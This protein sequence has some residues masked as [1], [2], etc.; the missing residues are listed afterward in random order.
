MKWQITQTVILGL[1]L[2]IATPVDGFQDWPNWRGPNHDDKSTE[3][4]LLKSWPEDGPAQVWVNRDVGIGYGGISVADGKLFTVGTDEKGEFT[5]CLDSNSGNVLWTKH[6]AD[7][8]MDRGRATKGWGD[9]SRSTPSVDGDKVYSMGASGVLAC[10]EVAN[11]NLVWSKKM[12]DL[13]GKVPTWGYS[14]S[15]LVDGNQVIC[16]PG[17][18]NGAVAAFDKNTGAKL[19]QSQQATSPAHYSSV[20]PVVVNGTKQYVQLLLKEAIGLNPENGAVIWSVPWEGRTAVIPSPVSTSEN[21]VYFTSGYGTGSMLVSLLNG[22][23]VWFDPG[24]VNHHGGVIHHEGFLYGFTDRQRGAFAVQD[25]KTGEIVNR[26]NS[27]KKGAISFAEG[28]LYFLEE[29]SGRVLLLEPNGKTVKIVSS[30]TL[31]NKSK[32]RARRGK[33]WVHP[34]IS[35]G[36]LYLRDQEIL[37]CFNI[38]Q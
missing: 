3:T 12:S 26:D 24:M 1:A 7:I 34:V 2:L 6:F 28:K 16:T 13:G 4:G 18:P 37:T 38:K 36:K 35:N 30:F 31:P 14:E 19:W 23:Q 21:S 17:G 20:L 32:K 10:F 33:I 5:I 15:P 8:G 9:G 22:K 25:A 29:Q 11:G 27:I